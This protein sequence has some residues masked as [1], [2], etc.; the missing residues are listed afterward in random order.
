MIIGSPHF[1]H[2]DIM[3][4][5]A[6]LTASH[7]VAFHVPGHYI[8]NPTVARQC[9]FDTLIQQGRVVFLFG[10]PRAG[11]GQRCAWILV[12]KTTA[13]RESMLRREKLCTAP[14]AFMF[15]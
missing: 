5:L 4:P 14:L 13:L 6:V 1:L 11:M 10:L 8:S 7:L 2:L 15:A 3:L 12:F 9:Y